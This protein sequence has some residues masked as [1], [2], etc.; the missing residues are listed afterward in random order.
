MTRHDEALPQLVSRVYAAG[1][2]PLRARILETLLQPLRPL[3]LAAVAAGAFGRYLHRDAWGRVQVSVED[4]LAFS[5][6]QVRD[7]ALF[8]LEVAPEALHQA[9]RLVPARQ[10]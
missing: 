3:A 9:A 6:E 8:V 4:A 10:A 7:L 1:P 5:A 2:A